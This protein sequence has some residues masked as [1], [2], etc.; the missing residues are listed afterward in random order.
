MTKNKTESMR[1]HV[2]KFT[3]EC[4]TPV[5]Y[6]LHKQTIIRVILDVNH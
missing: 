1:E 3:V 5:E 2:S 6:F 4:S